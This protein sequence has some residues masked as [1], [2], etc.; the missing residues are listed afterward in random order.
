MNPARGLVEL[1]RE[2]AIRKWISW[3]EKLLYHR[4]STARIGLLALLVAEYL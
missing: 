3:N 2:R 4:A 1:V